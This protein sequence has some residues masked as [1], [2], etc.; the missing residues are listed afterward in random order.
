MEAGV[1]RLRIA[2]WVVF[3][4]GA[5]IRVSNCL[6]YPRFFGFDAD[7]NWEYVQRLCSDWA[8][9]PPDA[10]WAFGHPPLFYYLAAIVGRTLGC[11]E[12]GS[13]LV[14]VRLIST[15]AG[16][17]AIAATLTLVRRVDPG[18]ERRALFAAGLLLFL[19]AHI[20][21]SATFGEE[22]LASAFATGAIALASWSLVSPPDFVPDRGRASAVGLLAGLGW[23]T[24]LTGVLVLPAVICAYLLEGWRRQQLLRAA[25]RCAMVVLVAGLV[26]GWFYGR[27][28]IRYGYVYPH[29]LPVHALMLKQPPGERSVVDYLYVPVSTFTDSRFGPELIRSVWGGTYSTLWFDA[30]RHFLP[31]RDQTVQWAG[32]TILVLALLPV[33]AFAVGAGSGLRRALMRS[34][35]PDLPLL[36]LLGV[37]IAGYVLFT[38]RNPWYSTVKGTYLLGAMLPFAFYA[39]DPLARWTE[40]RGWRS[41]A[42]WAGLVALAITVTLT[43]TY[44]LVWSGGHR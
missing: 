11:S 17:A 25:G 36:I 37:T 14:V 6:S 2:L 23:L 33:F 8:L 39:S 30:H 27:N 28:L 40:G 41:V 3:T 34:G 15:A 42:T 18:N 4:V 16:L 10:G 13:G 22:V 12:P 1:P 32:T 38:W 20:Q 44:G 43:F 24:K 35:Q 19:P 21:M 7:H 31:G 9:P 29:G 5:V 26:G